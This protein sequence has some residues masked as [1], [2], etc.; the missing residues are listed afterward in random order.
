[1]KLLIWNRWHAIGKIGMML[2]GLR[3]DGA[4][5]AAAKH[6]EGAGS[7]SHMTSIFCAVW[8][9]Y[10]SMRMNKCYHQLSC[11]LYFC[12]LMFLPSPDHLNFSANGILRL[13]LLRQLLWTQMVSLKENQ[14]EV[15]SNWDIKG[16]QPTM[17]RFE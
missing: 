12:C 11:S 6:V 4:E 17:R 5:P 3:V 15:G 9:Y 13:V 2:R 14:S 1:V 16:T 7:A 10:A 8:L